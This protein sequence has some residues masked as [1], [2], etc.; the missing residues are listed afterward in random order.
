[1]IHELIPWRTLTR[2]GVPPLKAA[3]R[4]MVVGEVTVPVGATFNPELFPLRIRAE[5]LRQF[6]EMRLL[7]PVDAPPNSRQFYL[8]QLKR[9]QGQEVPIAPIQPV[10]SRIVADVDLPAI[11]IPVVE[12]PKPRPAKGVK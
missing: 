2:L 8:E 7:E 4:P 12:P 6:Y 10:A 5:R 1:M 11:E 3:R 9:M